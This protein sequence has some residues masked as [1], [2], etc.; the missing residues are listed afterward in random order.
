LIRRLSLR[1]DFDALRHD[2]RTVRRGPLRVRYLASPG[3]V[4]DPGVRVA[5]GIGR[6][7]G[8]GVVR[9]RLRRRLRAAMTALDAAGRLPAGDYLVR[10]EP[11]AAAATYRDLEAA[12]ETVVDDL[13]D[14]A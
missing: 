4:H 2:G 7:V 10:A 12:L 6:P 1:S 13:G 3:G 8:N 11:R 5:Y 9:N 14:G